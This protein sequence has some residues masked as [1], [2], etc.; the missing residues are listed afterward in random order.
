MFS[1]K[2]CMMFSYQVGDHK[3][4]GKKGQVA[5]LQLEVN[6]EEEWEKLL[7]KNGLI[8]KHCNYLLIVVVKWHFHCKAQLR[9]WPVKC[10][11]TPMQ[12][13]HNLH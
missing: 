3:M 5:Q 2:R 6:T 8:G 10:S 12:M 11:R 1:Q 7:L 9:L 4:A 13:P